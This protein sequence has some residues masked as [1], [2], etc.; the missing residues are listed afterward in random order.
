M[1]LQPLPPTR[2]L[3]HRRLVVSQKQFE[4]YAEQKKLLLLSWIGSRFLVC[5][6]VHAV[7]VPTKL[8]QVVTVNKNIHVYYNRPL[9]VISRDSPMDI[10]TRMTAGFRFPAGATDFSLLHSVQNGSE[11]H[12]ASLLMYAGGSFTRGKATWPW[13]WAFTSL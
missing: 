1:Q 9:Q 11:G 12:P 3:L 7:Y 6:A 4:R 13:S 2:Y 5:P 8:S 10:A